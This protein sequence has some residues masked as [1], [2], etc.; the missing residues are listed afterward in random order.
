MKFLRSFPGK[1]PNSRKTSLY[2]GTHEKDGFE[3]S[4][5]SAPAHSADLGDMENGAVNHNNNKLNENN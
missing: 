2:P 4:G 3:N 5:V 1:N